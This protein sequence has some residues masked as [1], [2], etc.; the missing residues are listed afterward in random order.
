MPVGS[1]ASGEL[2]GSVVVDGSVGAVVFVIGSDVAVGIAE[3][4][5]TSPG[6]EDAVGAFEF[7]ASVSGRILSIGVEDAFGLSELFGVCDV[8]GVSGLSG[9][10]DASGVS[11]ALGAPDAFGL[12]DTFG[13]SELS[14][15]GDAFGVS[16]TLGVSE[17][18]G[19]PVAPGVS[20]PFGAADGL[21]E[22]VAGV[23]VVTGV[24]V[25]TTEAAGVC[26]EA[27]EG[28]GSFGV[29]VGF[30]AVFSEVS[31]TVMTQNTRTF[32]FFLLVAVTFAVPEESAVT[33]PVFVT[34]TINLLFDFQET[35]LLAFFGF[36]DFTFSL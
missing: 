17:L 20:V 32:L 11:D 24:V 33:F 16:D 31:F 10:W 1:S 7:G 19:A 36:T 21:G 30:T 15:A 13:A 25:G 18:S 22:V 9:A 23:F 6:L 26:E 27:A 29:S 4:V 8:L 12:S 34:F 3:P 5:A 35:A 28:T 14:G 2:V